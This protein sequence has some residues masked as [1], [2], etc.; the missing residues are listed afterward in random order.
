MSRQHAGFHLH[1]LLCMLKWMS[2]FLFLLSHTWSYPDPLTCFRVFRMPSKTKANR[3]SNYSSLLHCTRHEGTRWKLKPQWWL[4]HHC[5]NKEPGSIS[6]EPWLRS[7]LDNFHLSYVFLCSFL[8][9]TVQFAKWPFKYV[10]SVKYNSHQYQCLTLWWHQL[11][12][13]YFCAGYAVMNSK[14]D[15]KLAQTYILFFD[16]FTCTSR[17]KITGS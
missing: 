2:P 13:R 1:P 16:H 6:Q 12:P 11:G 5:L 10:F 3:C 14:M 7:F 8:L 4:L 9:P 17:T 15:C